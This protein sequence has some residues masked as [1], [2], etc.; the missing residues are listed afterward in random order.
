MKINIEQLRKDKKISLRQL[1]KRS[2]VAQGYLSQLETGK[3]N[4]PTLLIMIKLC[5]VLICTLNDLVDWKE[6][7]D[8]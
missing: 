4:N 6:D 3:F 2:G 8:G 5:K 1:S 7:V